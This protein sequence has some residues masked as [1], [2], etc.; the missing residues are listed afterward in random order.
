MSA[1]PRSTLSRRA[2]TAYVEIPPSPFDLHQYQSLSARHVPASNNGGGKPTKE[3][4][5]LRA[6]RLHMLQSASTSTS[7]SSSLK[8][9]L[10]DDDSS[11]TSLESEQSSSKKAKSASTGTPLKAAQ[12][13]IVP[14]QPVA[15][16]C[17]EFPNGWIYCHQCC[18]KRDLEATIQ[19]T[20]LESKHM[21]KT[22]T[23]KQWRCVAKYCKPCLQ[24]RYE[25][26]LENLKSN[27]KRQVGHV[28]NAGYYFTCPKCRDMCNCPRCRKA[29]GLDP[30]GNMKSTKT[31]S[32]SANEKVPAPKEKKNKSKPAKTQSAP[33]QPKKR[34]KKPKP[35]VLPAVKWTRLAPALSQD[36]VEER[37]HIRE[38]A[39]RF[40]HLSEAGLLKPQLEELEQINGKYA[41]HEGQDPSAWV[42]DV[43]AKAVVPMLLGILAKDPA[44]VCVE[45]S[46]TAIKELRNAGFSLT[47][48]W[49]T[50]QEWEESIAST[51]PED[52]EPLS[53][54]EPRPASEF[55]L[56]QARR[57]TRT[58]ASAA[59]SNS[60]A[61][62]NSAQLIPP[63]L[64]LI[65]LTLE[66]PSMREAIDEGSKEAR[67][68]T[69]KS[70]EA[71]Q[72]EA[73][74]WDAVKKVQE[75][76]KDKATFQASKR[77]HKDI[78]E[79]LESSAQVAQCESMVRFAPLA[80]D[81]DGHVFYALAPGHG[82]LGSRNRQ[83][84]KHK[85][86]ALKPSERED[87][88]DWSWMVLVYGK[89]PPSAY[90]PIGDDD[91]DE[92]MDDDNVEG[93]WCF[94]DPTDIKELAEWLVLAY[95]LN[96]EDGDVDPALKQLV[97]SL[98]DFANLLE[99]RS[100]EDKYQLPP[101]A[102]KGKN[103]K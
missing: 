25:E 79:A 81:P 93:W 58:M 12:L 60:V 37:M 17:E 45:A 92:D 62:Y 88:H 96:A 28:D 13:N 52:E 9:K 90:C 5:P 21:T 44:S 10:S 31:Q 69:R 4:T 78:V 98:K 48:V 97:T 51:V 68:V 84:L 55:F 87:A 50:L 16:A 22:N 75:R 80:T 30:V 101:I 15:N 89:K 42:S 65:D 103:G 7:A 19:C 18:K 67:E 102:S 23:T 6:P 26:E 33:P 99:W 43:C 27:K 94:H 32:A 66:L 54:E 14:S 74:R 38:F 34:V 70:R 72:V 11:V 20:S 36:D 77:L 64:S 53:L 49:T 100:K 1:T 57:S 59:S 39:L 40:N 95:D 3:N 46:E 2:S 24:N 47:K 61:I 71:K 86:R 85:A 91:S 56:A 73:E 82:E 83:K 8:R 35:K 41:G 76:S 63:I 29:K